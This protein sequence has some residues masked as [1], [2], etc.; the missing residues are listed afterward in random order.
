[1]V[2]LDG[3]GRPEAVVSEADVTAVPE[4]RRPWTTVGALARRIEAGLVLSPDLE[5]EGLVRV[6][7]EHPASEYVVLDGAGRLVGV[8]AASDVARRLGL[9]APK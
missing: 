8:V 4:Q 2:V 6:L 1:M 7:R 9:P 3:R 5:G